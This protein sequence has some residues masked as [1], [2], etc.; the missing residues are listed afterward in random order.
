MDL[1]TENSP[2]TCSTLGLDCGTCMHRGASSVAA[3]CSGLGTPGI[4]PI[5]YQMYPSPACH[6]MVDAFVMAY[7][8]C[9]IAKPPARAFSIAAA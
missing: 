3:I 1:L 6:R 4:L 2:E 7:Q 5:F 9:S 8:E